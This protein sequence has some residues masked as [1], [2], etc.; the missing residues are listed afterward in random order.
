VV[1]GWVSADRVREWGSW[2]MGCLLGTHSVDQAGL[3]LRNMPASATQVLGLKTC[4]TTAQP[5]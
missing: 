5:H 4:T 2:F 3:K 1:I